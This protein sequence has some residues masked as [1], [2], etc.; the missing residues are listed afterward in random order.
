MNP[1]TIKATMTPACF[2][3]YVSNGQWKMAKHHAYMDRLLCKAAKREIKRLIVEMPPR[4]GKSLLGSQYFPAWWLGTFPKDNVIL[5]SA[6]GDL[7]FDFS[8]KARDTLQEF[9]HSAFGVRI[10]ADRSAARRWQLTDGG[11]LRAA[12]VGTSIVG[13][14]ADLFIVDDYLKDVQAALS[15]TQRNHI[16]AWFHSVATTRMSPDGVIV[17]I[18]TRWHP[19][20][21]IGRLLKETAAGGEYWER[22][23]FPAIAEDDDELGRQAGEA[24]WEER[25]PLQW[26]VR[27]RAAYMASGYPWQWES[28]Y[29]QNPPQLLDAEWEANYFAESVMFDEWPSADRIQWRLVT[30]DPSLGRTDKSDYSAFIMMMLDTDGVMW[31]DADLE[32]RDVSRMVD[33]AINICRAFRANAFCCEEVGFQAALEPLFIDRSSASGFMI[34]Y[35]GM[36]NPTNKLMRIRSTLTPFLRHNKFRFKSHSPGT[37]LLL[38]QLKGFPSHRHDDGP[39]ALEM[40]VRFA[41]KVHQY[42]PEIEVSGTERVFA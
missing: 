5:T 19:D 41:Q 28:L 10:R 16:H 17:I 13:H 38:E 27:R 30:L 15:E 9:G 26:L 22:I 24:L 8:T 31:I 12:G 39:D 34:P 21:L 3:R 40:A 36:P 35:H 11:G 32:R 37:S 7:A 29:Q 20:D 42:G 18:A 33:D 6:T 23:R 2:A 14:G 25:Y 4:H 1:E